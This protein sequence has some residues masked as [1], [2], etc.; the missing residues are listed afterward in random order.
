MTVSN[1]ED[2]RCMRDLGSEVGGEQQ[3]YSSRK[4][5]QLPTPAQSR[6]WLNHI[7]STVAPPRPPAPVS[8]RHRRALTCKPCSCCRFSGFGCRTWSQWR[9]QWW[10][11][12]LPWLLCW[13]CPGSRAGSQLWPWLPKCSEKV[14]RAKKPGILCEQKSSPHLNSTMSVKTHTDGDGDRA[15]TVWFRQDFPRP[16]QP[17]ANQPLSLSS[18]QALVKLAPG[19]RLDLCPDGSCQCSLLLWCVRKTFDLL[20]GITSFKHWNCYFPC[21][22]GWKQS[23]LGG[24]EIETNARKS[25]RELVFCHL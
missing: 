22:D 14:T 20:R 10:H 7:H 2:D 15:G 9:A 12:F 8:L 23:I 17:R 24:R 21:W 19:R 3:G 5:S 1:G 11:R 25:T 16:T 4:L 13:P 18:S 6:R